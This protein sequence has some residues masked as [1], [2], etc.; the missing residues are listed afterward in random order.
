[1]KKTFNILF[2]LLIIL[3]F[4][5]LL[6]FFS[7]SIFLPWPLEIIKTFFLLFSKSVTY[8]D[9]GATLLRMVVGLSI[10]ILIGIP[11]G[12]LFGFYNRIYDAFEFLV[13]FS[14]SVP[15]PALFPLFMLIF[16]I[17]NGSKIAPIVFAC[18]FYIMINT[19]YGVKNGKK[20]RI[21]V[22]KIFGLSR[23][24]IFRQIIFP[25]ALP[26][27]FAGLRL[28]ISLSLILA[29]VFEMFSGTTYG[30]GRRILDFQLLY[31]IPEMYAMILV[32]GILGYL[33]NVLFVSFER[34]K[35]H[36]SGK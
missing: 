21:K 25:E 34:K 18:T 30:V 5:Y 19:M 8:L 9:I 27:I 2:S 33:L 35:I 23:I 20:L 17:G 10:A 24:N 22:G 31:D 15:P 12:L 4:W 29:I 32:A 36:W 7:Q 13:D 28:A 11:L 1:M 3:I 26:Y 6:V 16:G 14:R